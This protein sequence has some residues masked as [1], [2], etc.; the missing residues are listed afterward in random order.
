[1]LSVI[2]P[3]LNAAA[4]IDQ[5]LEA[6]TQQTTTPWEVIISDTGST[7]G[8]LDIIRRYSDR[9][10]RLKIVDA[11]GRRGAGHARNEGVKAA[12]GATT[13]SPSV[14]PMM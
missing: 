6:L 12:T 5:Q 14:M 11:S 8:T 4:T 1:M 10:P 13:S 9:L 2:I 3:C 7:D